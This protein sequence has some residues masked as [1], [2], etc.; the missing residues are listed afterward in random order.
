MVKEVAIGEYVKKID[1]LT[2]EREKLKADNA[3]CREALKHEVDLSA[4][5][6]RQCEK[7]KAQLSKS[8]ERVKELEDEIEG[9]NEDEFGGKL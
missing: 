6:L 7:L 4:M 5:N 1:S 8:Q 2:R 3:E 9:L